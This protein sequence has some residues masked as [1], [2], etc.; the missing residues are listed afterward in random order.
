MTTTNRGRH[1][2]QTNH[3]TPPHQLIPT[4]MKAKTPR[5]IIAATIRTP[6]PSQQ[7]NVQQNV[8]ECNGRLE[9]LKQVL[10]HSIDH[11]R[12]S[13]RNFH[14]QVLREMEVGNMSWRDHDKIWLK[15][16][17]AASSSV[18]L[19]SSVAP[20]TNLRTGD[21]ANGGFNRSI[22]CNSYNFDQ[23]GCRYER[24]G[25]SCKKLHA[26]STCA[27]EGFL[28]LHRAGFECRKG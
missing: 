28:N 27:A 10:Q 5:M 18:G 22:M 12:S 15:G 17:S 6:D 11:G 2:R 14:Y 4:L 25:A 24:N 7:P 1:F 9:H 21:T 3:F 19:A 16:L 8:V 26:C 13:A 23:A 20:S